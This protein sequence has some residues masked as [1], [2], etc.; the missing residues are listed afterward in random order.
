MYESSSTNEIKHLSHT[1]GTITKGCLI[2][3]EVSQ[4]FTE[5]MHYAKQD[6]Q[7]QIN[8][9]RKKKIQRYGSSCSDEI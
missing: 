9:I 8:N 6:K 1:G 2:T 4:K 5:T 3:H 7:T